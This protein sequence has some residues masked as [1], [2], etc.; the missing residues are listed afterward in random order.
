MLQ[1]ILITGLL[2]LRADQIATKWASLMTKVR[3]S[4]LRRHGI[5]LHFVAQGGHFFEIA[6]DLGK[7]SID[8]TSHLKSDTFIECG[9][10]V[11]IGRY[12]HPGRGLTIFSSNHNYAAG[13]RI[14]YDHI[15]HLLP[16]AIGD[17]VWCGANVTILPGVTVGEGAVIGAGSVVVKDIPRCAVVGGNPARVLKFRDI[18]HFDR[19]KA[20][21]L[22][23]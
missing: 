3:L 18:E 7:F 17:F 2:L 21:G 14:P 10:G 13:T 6:G 11:A 15:Q 16:V 23:E 19:L 1:R 4:R 5:D 20:A 22:F 8:P 9:G 12:F